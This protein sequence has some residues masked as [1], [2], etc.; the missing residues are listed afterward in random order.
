MSEEEIRLASTINHSVQD[1]LRRCQ[2][3]S[4][5]DRLSYLIEIMEWVITDFDELDVSWLKH[6]E[7]L[8]NSW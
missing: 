1:C 5:E 4:P 7:H 8:E 3:L 6:G 2:H